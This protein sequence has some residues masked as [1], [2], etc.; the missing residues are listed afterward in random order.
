V[1]LALIFIKRKISGSPDRHYWLILSVLFLML[2]MDEALQIHEKIT[3]MINMIGEQ[4]N[5]DAISERPGFL[6]YVWVIP[7]FVFVIGMGLFL[8][9]FL[10][11]LPAK[12][13]NLFILSGVIFVTGAVGLELF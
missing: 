8:F 12:T 5:I 2:A 11:R 3:N 1:L 13:R 10:M 9:N 4:G 7:Y 6:K